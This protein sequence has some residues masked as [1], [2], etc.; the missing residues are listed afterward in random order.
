MK[1]NEPIIFF[2]GVRFRVECAI[3][4]NDASESRDFIDALDIRKKAKIT[5]LIKRFA[6]AGRIRNKEQ[7]KKVTG[8]DFWEFK[9]NQIRVLMYHCGKGKIALTHGF[10]KKDDK[11]R[12]EEIERAYSIKG[13]YE[14]RKGG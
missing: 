2:N 4:K 8:T 13:E 6:N 5:S 3:R 12:K 1:T 7:F 9:S 11:I 10:V 14:Q